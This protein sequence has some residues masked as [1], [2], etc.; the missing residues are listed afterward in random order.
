MKHLVSTEQ[1]QKQLKKLSSGQ[2]QRTIKAL[3]KLR[4]FVEQEKIPQGLGFKKINGDKYEIRVDIRLRIAL[5][6][7]GGVLA[8]VLIGNHDEIKHYLKNYRNK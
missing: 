1:F 4:A 8:C 3:K 7:E 2:Q 6:K 5:K